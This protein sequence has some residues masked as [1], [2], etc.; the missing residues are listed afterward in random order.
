MTRG[1][2]TTTLLGLLAAA[3]LLTTLRQDLGS[4]AVHLGTARLD[5]GDPA[6]AEAAFHWAATLGRDA[7]PLA[8]NLG[9]S[10]YRRGD[11]SGAQ[12]QFA[13]ALA[14]AGADLSPTIRYN[15]GN[16]QFRRGELLAA[17]RPQDA[18][19]L[20]REAAADYG[21]A[22]AEDPG[23]TDAA[24][25]LAVARARLAAL[26]GEASS[27]GERPRAGAEDK[28]AAPDGRGSKTEGERTKADPKGASPQMA[29]NAN[30]EPRAD[31]PVGT[32][33]RRLDLARPEVE[34]LLNEAR[35]REKPAGTLHAGSRA[36]KLAQP[37]KDW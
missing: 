13:A 29:A 1:I 28:R 3:G 10:L 26:G 7:A 5:D 24:N 37:D 27:E 8:Y 23:A 36:G 33:K 11:F 9:V 35:G 6:G 14:V 30:G 31:A 22:L 18:R 16:C 25:N 4:L 19:S 2:A 20:L 15:R 17:G 12:Q 34:R 32:A 21:Q